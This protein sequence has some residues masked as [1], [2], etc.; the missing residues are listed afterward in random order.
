V[1]FHDFA[2][3]PQHGMT[4]NR[5]WTWFMPPSVL[6]KNILIKFLSEIIIDIFSRVCFYDS[7]WCEGHVNVFDAIVA[8]I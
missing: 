8:R 1:F 2:V 5:V 4:D 7:V 6:S 3:C